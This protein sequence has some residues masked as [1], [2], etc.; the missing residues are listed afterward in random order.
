M[1]GRVSEPSISLETLLKWI[2]I[3]AVPAF[4]W[5]WRSENILTSLEVRVADLEEQVDNYRET[6][7]HLLETKARLDYVQRL[8]DA[9]HGAPR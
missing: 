2:P 8:L 4:G 7:Q 1:A 9:E 5:V 6:E 3:L